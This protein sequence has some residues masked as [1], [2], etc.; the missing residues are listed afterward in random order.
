MQV[1]QKKL[2]NLNNSLFTDTILNNDIM[3]SL[4]IQNLNTGLRGVKLDK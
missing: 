4:L 2:F 1:I 3:L